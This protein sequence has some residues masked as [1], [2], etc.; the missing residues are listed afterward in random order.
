MKKPVVVSA[1]DLLNQ[2]LDEPS[3]V[4]QVDLLD[5]LFADVK[6]SVAAD[7]N[8]KAE[9]DRVQK[10]AKQGV[11]TPEQLDWL[12]H[13]QLQQAWVVQQHGVSYLERTCACG[14]VATIPVGYIIRYKHKKDRQA[15]RYVAANLK[16]INAEKPEVA[17]L[18]AAVSKRKVDI[19]ENC[20]P[21]H[22]PDQ[23]IYDLIC[24]NPH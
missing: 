7:A 21:S 3:Q 6:K 1:D 18:F 9:A 22:T 19:C 4:D 20:L 10:L 8:K 5:Q 2:F 14:N 24:E 13:F 16:M 11:A 23:T 17:D 15:V 12:L